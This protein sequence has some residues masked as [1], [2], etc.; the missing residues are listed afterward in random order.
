MESSMR[1]KFPG[2]AIVVSSLVAST[3]VARADWFR[4]SPPPPNAK[5]LSSIIKTVEDRGFGT[6]TEVEFEDGKW[7]IELHRASGK[8]IEIHVD[9]VSGQVVRN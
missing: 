7:E 8:E 4:D 2:F 5:P 1:F 6:I 9:P 3:F